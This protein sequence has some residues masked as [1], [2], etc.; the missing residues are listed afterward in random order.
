MSLALKIILILGIP[1]IIFLIWI[2][3]EDI[4]IWFKNKVIGEDKN[5]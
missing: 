1:C 2:Y 4:I 5:G 3:W